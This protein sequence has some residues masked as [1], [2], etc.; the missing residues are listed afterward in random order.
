[1]DIVKYLRRKP[2]AYYIS[3]VLL[4]TLK[5]TEEKR[6]DPPL[7]I[8]ISTYSRINEPYA[9]DNVHIYIHIISSRGNRLPSSTASFSGHWIARLG[10]GGWQSQK[11]LGCICLCLRFHGREVVWS[12]FSHEYIERNQTHRYIKSTMMIQSLQHKPVLQLISARYSS[13]DKRTAE[14]QLTAYQTQWF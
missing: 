10:S 6:L 4:L 1:M 8:S 11:D 7:D 12:V 14:L 9:N 13:R 5:P 2:Q 3:L